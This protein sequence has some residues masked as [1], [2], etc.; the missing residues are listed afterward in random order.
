MSW[1]VA[2]VGPLFPEASCLPAL[3]VVREANLFR[4]FMRYEILDTSDL[5]RAALR[6]LDARSEGQPGYSLSGR[7]EIPEM[8]QAV[9]INQAVLPPLSSAAF[10]ISAPHPGARFLAPDLAT[11]KLCPR[12][13]SLR[14]TAELVY[15]Q[16]CLHFGHP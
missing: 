14:R 3:F 13:T 15:I 6:D 5:V 10:A 12:S 2:R 16:R 8:I 4:S 9:G 1:K 11:F 7:G